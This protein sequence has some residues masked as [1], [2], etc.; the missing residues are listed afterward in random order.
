MA[1]YTPSCVVLLATYNGERWLPEQLD[2]IRTQQQVNVRIVASDDQSNDGTL[3]VLNKYAALAP[4]TILPAQAER[5]GN[6]N[7]NFLRLIRDADIGDA[8]YIALADQ[9]D[10]WYSNKL[11]RAVSKLR[12]ERA[13][14]YS[15]DVEAFWPN[16]RTRILK[17]SYPQKRLDHVFGSPG[18][19]CTFVFTRALF[20]EVRTWITTNFA[21]LSKLW[22]HDWILYAYARSKGHRW[23]IDDVPTMRYRQHQSNEIGA[24]SGIDAIR[25]R[26][27]VVKEGRYR[28][29]IIAISE[30]TQAC[31]KCMNALRR[32]GWRD[33][34]WL[35]IHAGEFRRSLREILALRIIFVLMPDT[36]LPVAQ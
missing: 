9:D 16:G 26:L 29:N 32:L 18:P 8:E 1:Q 6:A 10:I 24:N 25:R 7:R 31:P 4:F 3:S 35:I 20:L 34:L 36:P 14:A 17:K 30:L 28:Y 15:S 2:S 21:T 12:S 5:F 33:R 22:V 23:V 19:G 13:D 27:A 11:A